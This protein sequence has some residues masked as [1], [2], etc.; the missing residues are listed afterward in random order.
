MSWIDVAILG[1]VV[2]GGLFG[3]LRGVKK[4]SLSLG[5]FVI[6]FVL[7]FFLA[8]VIAEALLGIDS[9]KNFVFGNGVGADKSWSLANWLYMG[10]SANATEPSEYILK[11]FYKPMTD[12]MQD[13][14]ITEIDPAYGAAVY[15]AFV[16]FSAI[17]G[18]GIFIVARFLLIIVI[19]VIKSY[20]G[21]KK[22][23]MSRLTGF[24]VGAVQGALWMF[25][26]TLV[27]SCFGG[28]TFF[29]GFR[30]VQNEFENNPVFC[31]YINDGAYGLKNGLLLPDKNAYGRLVNIVNSNHSSDD[32]SPEREK[33]T[34]DRLE[35]FI[36]LKN[37][38]Y[39]NAPWSI[40]TDGNR[41]RVLDEA[42]AQERTS[43][44]FADV[45]YD[46]IAAAIL[47]YNERV[48]TYVDNTGNT[49]A[50]DDVT[51]FKNLVKAESGESI[52]S[53]MTELWRQLG[54]YVLHYNSPDT[55]KD[56]SQNNSTLAMDYQS[57]NE[58]IERIKTRY[59]EIA[60]KVGEFPTLTPPAQMVLTEQA[61]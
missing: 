49:I 55:E 35:L 58:T 11:N 2:L 8:N 51:T 60:K 23:V 40:S 50:T 52:D 24:V 10:S 48:A 27:F 31:N 39:T 59:S 46:Q 5:A 30:N 44:E 33:L 9:V 19:V 7:A 61:A 22:S 53:L 43:A 13:A 14:N 18:V 17:C 54:E 12:I 32:D 26:A 57:I 37:L 56:L 45:G 42:N 25:A 16:I 28:Y 20:I 47:E 1:V 29:V 36:N 4:S 34:G 21:K 41:K 6:A 15:G 38:K 3:V